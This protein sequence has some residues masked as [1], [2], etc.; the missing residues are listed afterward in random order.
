MAIMTKE[1]TV[2]VRLTAVE[3]KD[4]GSGSIALAFQDDP[5]ELRRW[6][7]LDAQGRTTSV[8]LLDPELGAT[9]SPE[10]FRLPANKPNH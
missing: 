4:P 9:L 2:S 7:V 8:A 5:L 6:S 10:L 3:T 1:A